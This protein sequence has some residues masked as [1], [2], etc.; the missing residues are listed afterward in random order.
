MSVVLDR[1]SILF[2]DYWCYRKVDRDY[3][4]DVNEGI[5]GRVDSVCVIG[6]AFGCIDE[7]VGIYGSSVDIIEPYIPPLS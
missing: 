6:E 4:G 1:V 5:S 3:R 2:W 7:G